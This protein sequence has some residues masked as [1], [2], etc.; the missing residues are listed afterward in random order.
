MGHGY[1]WQNNEVFDM[2]VDDQ[3]NVY[4][5][6]FSQDMDGEY[7]IYSKNEEKHLISNGEVSGIIRGIKTVDGELL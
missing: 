5:V 3:E 2:F 4:L 1:G 6:G 7:P